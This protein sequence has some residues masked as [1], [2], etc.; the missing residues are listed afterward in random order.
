MDVHCKLDELLAKTECYASPVNAL[1][2][3]AACC[4]AT[5]TTPPTSSSWRTSS[6]RSHTSMR[7]TT[8]SSGGRDSRNWYVREAAKPRP[9]RMRRNRANAERK[10]A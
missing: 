8:S 2:D 5:P 1:G 9:I 4:T 6:A 7:S 3:T 10:T